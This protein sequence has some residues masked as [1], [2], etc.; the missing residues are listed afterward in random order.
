MQTI[1]SRYGGSSEYR[2]DS[3][4][5]TLA[6]TRGRE[7][8]SDVWWVD[9]SIFTGEKT[10]YTFRIRDRKIRSRPTNQQPSETR[11][12]EKSESQDVRSR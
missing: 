10:G 12:T 6:D 9:L 11:K 5:L 2:R 1:G 7:F 8:D 4:W 3:L